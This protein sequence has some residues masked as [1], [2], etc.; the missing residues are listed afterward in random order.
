MRL[1]LSLTAAQL[2]SL[3][4]VREFTM[5]EYTKISPSIEGK[6]SALNKTQGTLDDVYRI[7]DR[8]GTGVIVEAA[9]NTY[10]KFAVRPG[11]SYRRTLF[12]VLKKRLRAINLFSRLISP[13]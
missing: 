3:I 7:A 11:L 4:S 10:T 13:V 2:Q 1:G 8:L 12:F 6:W 5:I 9:D